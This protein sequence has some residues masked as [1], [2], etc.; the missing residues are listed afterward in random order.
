MPALKLSQHLLPT[1]RLSAFSVVSFLH[2]GFYEWKKVGKEKQR[3]YFHRKDDELFA[4]AGLYD[5]WRDPDG[6]DI[7]SYT[8]ITTT[9]ND[10]VGTVHDRMP[11]ILTKEHEKLWLDPDITEPERLQPFL[12]PYPDAAMEA[13]PV[14]SFI[15][16]A[17]SIKPPLNSK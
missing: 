11:V 12:L 13:Y 8:I 3:Y 16:S 17:E 9:P 15:D 10:T 14:N 5:T 7:H 1:K 4:F 2:R 6:K